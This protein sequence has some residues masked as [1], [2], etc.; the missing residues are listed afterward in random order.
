MK[1]QHAALFYDESD[2]RL[3]LR[4]LN[5]EHGVCFTAGRSNTFMKWSKKRITHSTFYKY[6]SIHFYSVC[7][8]L[9]VCCAQTF[10]NEARIES[11]RAVP[12]APSDTIRVGYDAAVFRVARVDASAALIDSL[13][14][15]LP[16]EPQ[17]QPQSQPNDRSQLPPQ[18]LDAV[19]VLRT[20][21]MCTA[22]YCTVLH[23]ESTVNP[24]IIR[25]SAAKEKRNYNNSKSNTFCSLLYYTYTTMFC[26]SNLSIVRRSTSAS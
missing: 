25:M 15:V 8:R 13:D 17:P 10:V 11:D 23:I 22:L 20:T 26:T 24:F 6:K 14:F 7:I 16:N 19:R 4:D 21:N 3:H 18:Q 9:H 2:D 5:T 12:L 1:E